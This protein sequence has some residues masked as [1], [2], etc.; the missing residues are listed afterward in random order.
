MNK[1]RQ[2]SSEPI[3][4]VNQLCFPVNMLDN[5]EWVNKAH[6]KI[7]VGL[8]D[9]PTTGKTA[10]KVLNYCSPTYGLVPNSSIFPEIETILKLN[11]IS[12]TA[13]YRHVDHV[14]FYVDYLIT[15]S[16]F[17]FTVP[18]TQDIVQMKIS[19]Q[20]S[21]NSAKVFKLF[22]GWFRLICSNGLVMP[23]REL[24]KFNLTIVVKHATKIHSSL[25]QFNSMLVN[26]QNNC[27]EIIKT[28][29]KKMNKLVETVITPENFDTMLA[30]TLEAAGIKAVTNSKYCTFADIK[31]RTMQEAN[32]P[33][34][35][36]KGTV[37][38]WLVYN[39]INQ[40][41]NDDTLNVTN[42]ETRQ[43]TDS[44]VLEY[45]LSLHEVE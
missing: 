10:R 38:Q 28:I 30:E 23:V 22:F 41:I 34:L 27:D 31:A 12:F 24:E 21:Y 20:H 5:P 6:S 8:L 35:G 45:L 9:N 17:S 13:T 26:L 14:E 43:I 44:K 32:L 37:N 40:Y 39:A 7:V 4:S 33:N 1:Q 36:Y 2:N 16:R 25:E 15:D 11:N 29:G 18:R 3:T 19:V 42:P